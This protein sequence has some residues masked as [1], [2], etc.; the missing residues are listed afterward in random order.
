MRLDQ[1]IRITLHQQGFTVLAAVFLLIVLAGL[2]AFLVNVSVTQQVGAALDIQGTRAY[3]AAR[4]GAEWGAYQSL[5]NGSCTGT[6]LTFA[7]TTLA[8]FS[9]TVACARTSVDEAGTP[10]N[11]DQITATACNQPVCPNNSPGQNYIERQLV[12]TVGR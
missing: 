5:R 8:D 9:T 11:V 10:V 1:K 7:G 12:I 3:Q 6:I 2:A 4:A